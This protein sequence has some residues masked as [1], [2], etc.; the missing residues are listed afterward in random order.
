M[1]GILVILAVVFIYSTVRRRTLEKQ[2][3]L[4]NKLLY[5]EKSPEKYIAEIDK[6]L[7]K[8]Q[9]EKERNIN[10]IQKTTGLLY[11]GEF[12]ESI[13][14]LKDS[15]SKI[16]SNW[17]VIYYHNLL[18]CM[19][20]SGDTKGANE[21]LSEVKDTIN[22]YYKKDYNKVTIELI[23][24]VSDFYNGNI[25]GCREFFSNLPYISKNDYRIAF[26][27]YFTGKI[28]EI[29][30]KAEDAEESL[31]K[32]MTFGRGSFIEKLQEGQR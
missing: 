7:L 19:Y 1:Y 3:E 27:Y 18:L 30:N 10:L 24:A 11:A 22:M 31:K 32:S 29:E 8:H 17:Q 2:V 20:L 13:T 9:T 14:I 25:A 5:R 21:L 16:P 15:V 6:L 28:Q 4:F 26:G 12:E 23:Y